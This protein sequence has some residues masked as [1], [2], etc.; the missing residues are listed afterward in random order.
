MNPKAARFL[1]LNGNIFAV[2]ES[3]LQQ[4]ELCSLMNVETLQWLRHFHGHIVEST[5]EES[6][7]FENDA[8]FHLHE[9][10][11][12]YVWLSC[13]NEGMEDM[14]VFHDQRRKEYVLRPKI[15]TTFFL[16]GYAEMKLAML[17]LQR[18]DV[19]ERKLLRRVAG[20]G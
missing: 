15:Y 16:Y 19:L 20:R 18:C 8:S 1:V 3:L 2:Q 9:L 13:C 10:A 6:A 14:C 12:D 17:F 4:E 11:E 7:V 5:R